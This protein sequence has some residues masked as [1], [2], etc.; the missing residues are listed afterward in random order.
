MFKKYQTQILVAAVIVLLWVITI[1]LF[2]G[3]KG[4][5][6]HY[7][8]GL[9]FGIIS[10][11]ITFASIIHSKQRLTKN[12]EVEVLPGIV[13]FMYLL[14]ALIMDV[15]FML[16]GNSESNKY[17]V[18]LNVILLLVF[19][20]AVFYSGRYGDRVNRSS[21]V[22]NEKVKNT[23]GA[24]QLL[25]V[26]LSINHD[27]EV[28]KA[29]RDLKMKVDYSNNLTQGYS[30][31]SEEAFIQKLMT[32]KKSVEDSESTETVL[33]LVAEAD[34]IWAERNSFAVTAH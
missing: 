13:S 30:T 10:I 7:W 1:L 34:T 22:M 8:G 19:G 18:G 4:Q 16:F 29:L 17:L 33:K 28:G 26:L 23:K 27:S 24:Q 12:T 15:C 32:I 2:T 3:D 25:S 31:Q 14:I 9:V 6:F 20:L 11:A 21:Q 5:G